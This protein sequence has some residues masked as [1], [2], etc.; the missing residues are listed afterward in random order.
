MTD[1]P[2]TEPAPAAG[3]PPVADPAPIEPK[4]RGRW[5]RRFLWLV[6]LTILGRVALGFVLEPIVR[7]VAASFGVGVS[8]ERLDLSVHSGRLEIWHLAAAVSQ[9]DEAPMPL[10]E[11]DTM[12]LD[13]DV[14]AL[15]RG[16]VRVRRLEVDGVRVDLARDAE[17]AWNF[18]PILAQFAPDPSLPKPPPKPRDPYEPAPIPLRLPVQIVAVRAQDIEISLRDEL[19]SESAFISAHI[20]IVAAN[21]GVPDRDGRLDVVVTSPQLL[22]AL[23]VRA[24]LASTE[25]EVNLDL[26]VRLSR[27][28]L[29]P[30]E[31]VLAGLGLEP[32]AERLDASFQLDARVAHAAEDRH[33]LEVE[34]NIQDA[35]V[36][37]DG[38]EA[39]ALDS[40]EIDVSELWPRGLLVRE[41]AVQGLRGAAERL[42]DGG[43]AVAGVA[44]RGGSSSSD[45]TSSDPT[46][47]DPTSS[48][49]A[50]QGPPVPDQGADTPESNT[51]EN[52]AEADVVEEPY[53]FGIESVRVSE[54]RLDFIDRTFDPPVDL[55]AFL[56]A[57]DAGPFEPNPADDEGEGANVSLSGRLPGVLKTF[58]LNGSV[59]SLAPLPDLT[60]ALEATGVV[61]DRVAPYLALLGIEPAFVD[62]SFEVAAVELNDG[63]V[64]GAPATGLNLSLTGIALHDEDTELGAI[65]GI[66]LDFPSGEALQI[67]VAG[68]R[69]VAKRFPNN[70]VQLMGLQFGGSPDKPGR[71]IQPVEGETDPAPVAQS[72]DP[73]QPPPSFAVPSI[74][75]P[76]IQIDIQSFVLIDES[77]DAHEFA[78]GPFECVIQPST[79]G[80]ADARAYRLQLDGTTVLAR[81]FTASI[82][83]EQAASGRIEVKATT[84]MGG[85]DLEQLRPWFSLIGLEP[86][87]S[88]GT[89]EATLAV[90][91]DAVEGRPRIDLTAGPVVIA[92]HADGDEREWLGL[93]QLDVENLV[94]GD[95]VGVD[96][97]RVV[98]PRVRVEREEDGGF[99]ALGLRLPPPSLKEP[100]EAVDSGEEESALPGFDAVSPAQTPSEPVADSAPTGPAAGVLRIGKFELEGAAF[101]LDDLTW[102]T[103]HLVEVGGD[104]E[105]LDLAPGVGATATSIDG[106]LRLGSSEL[107]ALGEVVLDPLDL[108]ASLTFGGEKLNGDLVE[109]Y[110]PPGVEVDLTDG[111]LAARLEARVAVTEAGGRSIS[112]TVDG[113]ELRGPD[114]ERPLLSVASVRVEMPRI[115]VANQV[116]EVD[117]VSVTGVAADVVR[118]ISGG[119]SFCGVRVGVPEVVLPDASRS[120]PP[121]D[122]LA[123][124]GG[125]VGAGTE[126]PPKIRLGRIE[127]E[128]AELRVTSEGF[129]D[130]P[131]LVVSSRLA[132][133]EPYDLDIAPDEDL[134]GDGA[135][136]IG[137][138]FEASIAPGTTT[139]EIG[140]DVSPF[141]ADPSLAAR[142]AVEGISG[143]GLTALAPEL[144]ARVDTSEFT[145]GSFKA[146][147]DVELDWRRR[148]IFDFNLAD[149]FGMELIV[150][151]V[152]LLPAPDADIALGVDRVEV[153]ARRI[154][155]RSGKFHFSR[156]E[157][158]RPHARARRTPEGLEIAGLLLLMDDPGASVSATASKGG[159]IALEDS[160]K[161]VD[162]LED[163]GSVDQG[164]LAGPETV[165]A[166]ADDESRPGEIKIDTILVRDVDFVF[167][168]TRAEPFFL[169]PLD[170]L[171]LEIRGL[172]TRALTEP[173]PIRFSMSMGAGDV[174]LPV[175][176]ENRSLLR[177]VTTGVLSGVSSAV[178][179]GEDEEIVYEQRPLFGE[180]SS[181]ARLILYP[182][183]SGWLRGNVSGFELVGLRGVARRSGVDIGDGV[184]E[185]DVRV[186]LSGKKGG[187]LESVS[188][189]SHLALS[190]PDS[191]PISRY[192]K[193]PAP[194]D[195]VLF[196]LK[197]EQGEHQIPLS[198]DFGE[199]GE[200][201]TGEIARKASSAFLGL[202][203]KALA[204]APMRAV[205]TVTDVVGL[206]GV[207]GSR[208]GKPKLAGMI[209]VLEFTP[210]DTLVRA[211]AHEQIGE[212]IEALE[213]DELLVVDGVHTLGPGDIKRAEKL[214]SPDSREAQRL[215]D[216]L[217]QRRRELTRSRDELALAARSQLLL[218]Q[219]DDFDD[220]RQ[221]L[222]G[223][224]RDLGETERA[225]DRVAALL[226]PGAEHRRDRRTR[227]AALAVAGARLDAIRRIF[228][229]AGIGPER[230]SLRSPRYDIGDAEGDGASL[231]SITLVTKGGTPPKGLI[232]TVLGWVG[233]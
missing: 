83:M 33:R 38:V 210:G 102:G 63:A 22:D 72:A 97:I 204:G 91:I 110:L 85:T 106:T 222:I 66:E 161:Q 78:V 20:S 214:A 53:Q 220:T 130:E 183:P 84:V 195:S 67:R 215:V 127:F 218:G 208:D 104:L 6:G 113:I 12:A 26:S 167:E 151:D 157:V 227:E 4:R 115:D 59:R 119:V 18:D 27:L 99:R 141:T 188:T 7:S 5:R 28:R 114:A 25:D 76:N 9:G 8:W 126:A 173:I 193:L 81:E 142:V 128:L 14:L 168:D 100:I 90:V 160:S 171:D 170:S 105:V 147:L 87:L 174:P 159:A 93:D 148:G 75:L 150:S 230:F 45:P 120:E 103:P 54:G 71:V 219:N 68:V 166:K 89:I 162:G 17:G 55:S 61:P 224:D 37:H 194:L 124:R 57:I 109:P 135:A 64:D 184:L 164:A 178:G 233:L 40:L 112:L 1:E 191:G 129:E 31:S 225:I 48:D 181:S 199:G 172:T 107:T 3:L 125:R 11:V 186:R 49:S 50:E 101:T 206:G 88:E 2:R 202:V 137:I 73:A 35:S 117:E 116:Y 111:V 169:F 209:A 92:E 30:L 10:L 60:L 190:E 158:V 146:T 153:V 43:F 82:D 203:T 29:R 77:A 179:M 189:F 133:R 152:A 196:V 41:V 198:F 138:D 32:M 118:T 197:N 70:T 154:T 136:L 13:V 212:I 228:L 79:P 221:R 149:G 94:I 132:L 201:S 143:A 74:V 140:V 36:L 180:V 156:V 217:R 96:L 207:F 144:V 24:Q 39:L 51:D 216:A 108:R 98:R 15:L 176:L 19:A 123:G 192:L 62:G 177:G 65:D 139:L 211:T 46:S 42:V 134:V 95:G 121:A 56:D 80:A 34:L 131:P 52:V 47:S 145:D 44:I 69:A 200:I 223:A 231:G 226:R 58:S 182:E 205:G 155:P 187:H 165:A 16:V 185:S 229:E 232:G 175:R 213:D 21:L 23:R 86:S 122:L 163:Q